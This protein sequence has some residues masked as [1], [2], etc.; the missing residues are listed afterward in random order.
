M[1]LQQKPH[2]TIEA[3]FTRENTNDMGEA[4][5][6][7]TSHVIIMEFKKFMYMQ[8]VEIQKRTR[9]GTLDMTKNFKK[10]KQWYFSSPFS[11]PPYIDRVWKL[12]I[13]YNKNYEEFCQK[14]CGGF[15]EREDPRENYQ[16][17]YALYQAG[18]AYL[19]AKKDIV[20]PF[21]NLWPKYNNV[22]EYMTDFEFN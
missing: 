6:P 10:D 4:L 22:N 8:A 3:R 21:H 18:L 17:S 15:V 1:N 5:M 2:L 12:L 19:E 7:Q 11:A 14:A 9:D 16:T 13:L 20:K